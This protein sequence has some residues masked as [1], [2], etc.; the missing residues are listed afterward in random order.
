MELV[1]SDMYLACN[2]DEIYLMCQSHLG[3]ES[4]DFGIYDKCKIGHS[5]ELEIPE[6]YIE[7]H[8]NF[9]LEDELPNHYGFSETDIEDISDFPYSEWT[10]KAREFGYTEFADSYNDKICDYLKSSLVLKEFT[11]EEI[12]AI[13]ENTSEADIEM[14]QKYE[15]KYEKELPAMKETAFDFNTINFN[16]GFDGDIKEDT[17]KLNTMLW[18]YDEQYKDILVEFTSVGERRAEELIN[19]EN[20]IINV[21]LQAETRD[22]VN[23]DMKLIVCMDGDEYEWFERYLDGEQ[24]ETAF[25]KMNDYAV[26]YEKVS[27]NEMFVDAMK[28]IEEYKKECGGVPLIDKPIVGIDNCY[29]EN[30]MKGTTV[31][32]VRADFKLSDYEL[33]HCLK[34]NT[35]YIQDQCGSDE[36]RADEAIRTT[37]FPMGV[38]AIVTRDINDR[39]GALSARLNIEVPDIDSEYDFEAPIHYTTYE[40]ELS[41][42]KEIDL[43]VNV[44][45]ACEGFGTTL[46]EQLDEATDIH[47]NTFNRTERITKMA[48]ELLQRYSIDIYEKNDFIARFPNE[49]E[50]VN[51]LYSS[52]ALDKS[53]YIAKYNEY[54]NVPLPFNY[55]D[56]VFDNYSDDY[57]YAD[58]T[59]D[60]FRQINEYGNNFG[61]TQEMSMEE[62]VNR[63]NELSEGNAEE[64]AFFR[65]FKSDFNYIDDFLCHLY[66][67]DV[68]KLVKPTLEAEREQKQGKSITKKEITD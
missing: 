11:D 25:N 15:I 19:D 31:A 49:M 14:I 41:P 38:T 24:K 67:A 10:D 48:S 60:L 44:N 46:E 58:F 30:R 34:E 12:Q 8:F 47:N 5:S 39:D 26:E 4:Y 2:N 18:L 22:N 59:D 52:D 6:I 28:D 50:D 27:L 1:S 16:D 7:G 23:Y 61:I 29:Y 53:R 43:I 35:T 33:L 55:I 17:A 9:L 68:T 32:M 40:V 54:D 64:K 66:E 13:K 65:Q 56:A 45:K 37:A 42:E 63:A 51:D 3:D 20:T 21:Y 57:I 62:I 36:S